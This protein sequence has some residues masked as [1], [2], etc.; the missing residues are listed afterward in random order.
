MRR[1]R[2]A[3]VDLVALA[4]EILETYLPVA[5]E[6]GRTLAPGTRPASAIVEGDRG[7]LFQA[8]ANLVENALRHCP[9]GSTIVCSVREG[10]DA[11]ELE[12]ADDGPGIPEHERAAVLGRF[13]RLERSRSE[14]GTGLGLSLVAAVAEIHHAELVLGDAGPGLSVRL[15]FVH[16]ARP[17]GRRPRAAAALLPGALSAGRRR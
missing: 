5:E 15:R 9:A 13:H 8:V 1:E 2:F 10:P 4:D 7:E 17:A 12:V 6:A 14:P 3:P 11:I 16:A